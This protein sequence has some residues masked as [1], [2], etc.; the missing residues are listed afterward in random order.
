MEGCVF[1]R[2]IAKEIP[3]DVV[4]EDDRFIAFLDIHPAAKGH[5]LVVPKKHS[6]DISDMDGETLCEFGRVV[7]KVAGAVKKTTQCDGINIVMNNGKAAGQI[8]FHAHC[9]VVPR[10]HGDGISFRIPRARYAEGEAAEVAKK[11]FDAAKQ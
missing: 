8:I 1:C 4:Y 2:I 11:I 7:Q 5:S 3:A 10:F 6:T 9:H